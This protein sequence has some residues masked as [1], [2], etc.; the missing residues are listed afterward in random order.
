MKSMKQTHWPWV[1]ISTV[2]KVLRLLAMLL[3]LVTR[4]FQQVNNML[5]N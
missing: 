2:A 3:W 1:L 5:S 4:D